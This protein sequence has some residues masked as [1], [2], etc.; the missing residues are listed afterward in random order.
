MKTARAMSIAGFAFALGLMC[1]AITQAT[2]INELESGGTATNNS[3]G[4]A[5]TIPGSA[6]TLPVPATVFN[7][8][9]FPTATIV[10]QGGS[11]DIDFYSFTATGGQIYID[12]DN[13]P[14]TFDPILSLFNSAGTLLADDDD[15]SPLD[16]G[17]ASI[18]DPFI[19]VF[20]L[21]GAGTYFIAV[22]TFPNRASVLLS[23]GGCSSINLTRPDGGF[24]GTADTG[25]Q[26]G[27]TNFA[28][29]GS[30][31]VDGSAYTMHV[32]VQ[33]P[34]QIQGR[35]PEPASILLLGSGLLGLAL[36]WK[37]AN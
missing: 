34:S 28:S 2:T 30:E 37:K 36:G 29:N 21:P 1:T 5:Q 4:T 27:N 11:T 31:P 14:Q 6:F 7:P 13:N 20:T 22:T 17:S 19:G 26:V 12:I 8:P 32:S 23:G 3:I 18:A 9:G 33:N 24:G 10:G 25:C 15:T 16:S 35:V